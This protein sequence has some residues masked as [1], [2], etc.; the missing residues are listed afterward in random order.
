[1]WNISNV[2]RKI[3]DR[4]GIGLRVKNSEKTSAWSTE[5]KHHELEN[6]NESKSKKENESKSKKENESK[7]K[8]KME[9][10]T[11]RIERETLE[12]KHNKK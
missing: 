5:M 3:I 9:Y 10:T 1:M 12:I 6:E 8:K 2:Q 11:Q 4:G 7:S